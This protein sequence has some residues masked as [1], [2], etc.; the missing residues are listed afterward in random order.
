MLKI[1]VKKLA[2]DYKEYKRFA[3]VFPIPY[4]TYWIILLL[5]FAL[6][7]LKEADYFLFVVYSLLI[8]VNLLDIYLTLKKKQNRRN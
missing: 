3:E 2:A 1:I 6:T 5:L 4:Y 7:R 8:G